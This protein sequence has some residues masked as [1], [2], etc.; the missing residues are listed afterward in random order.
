M[1]GIG[2]ILKLK[3]QAC[4]I[5]IKNSNQA[6]QILLFFVCLNNFFISCYKQ[7]GLESIELYLFFSSIR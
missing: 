4:G 1:P 7:V 2:A 3:A 6:S 5:V